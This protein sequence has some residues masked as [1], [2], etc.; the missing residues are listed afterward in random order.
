MA[1]RSFRVYSA[2]SFGIAIRHY[3]EQAGLTQQELAD[4]TGIDRTYLLRLERGTLQS[5]QLRRILRVLKQ[6]GV[7][8]V[9]QEADW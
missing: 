8:V 7:R 5:E 2:E 1:D 3:R 4:L 6:L 9:L